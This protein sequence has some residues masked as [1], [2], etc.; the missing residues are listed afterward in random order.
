VDTT[1]GA[2]LDS[3]VMTRWAGVPLAPYLDRFAAPVFVDNDANVMALSERA[4]VGGHLARFSDVLLVKASTGI[5]AGVVLDG[6]LRR[7]GLGA[8]G[9][10][11]HTKIAAAAGRVCRCGETGC[12]EAVAGGWALVQAM[13]HGGHAV[14]HVRDVVALA[15]VGEPGARQLVRDSGRQVGEVVA[16]AVNLLNPQAVVVGGDMAPAFDTFVAGLRESL[17]AGA[18]ALASRDLQVVAATPADR[19]GVVGCAALALDQVLGVAAV[20]ALVAAG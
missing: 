2:S 17:Y 16:A 3:P 1:A 4:H 18:T 5:G 11:G 9:E 14:D 6:A 7:G 19:T 12:L 15:A 8:A 13:Q 20:D 10:V